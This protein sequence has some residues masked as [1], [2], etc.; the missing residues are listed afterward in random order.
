MS[1]LFL[2]DVTANDYYNFYYN[3]VAEVNKSVVT[4]LQNT[5]PNRLMTQRAMNY[6]NNMLAGGLASHYGPGEFGVMSNFNISTGEFEYAFA[7]QMAGICGIVQKNLA[8]EILERAKFYCP[9]D[10]G[11]LESTGHIE[12]EDNVTKIVFDCPYA[13][14]VHEF[15]WK[16]HD[17]PTQAKFLTQA[18]YEIQNKYGFGW[19]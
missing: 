9:K 8:E 19:A 4:A 2:V 15:T 17:Y 1:D 14:Y 10:T 6:R 13:W 18:I 3:M 5:I 16:H 11:Y 12:E 7:D